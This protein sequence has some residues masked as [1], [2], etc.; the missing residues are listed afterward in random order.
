MAMPHGRKREERPPID[1]GGLERMALRYVER[2]ATSRGKL[3]RYLLRK[4]HERGWEGESEPPVT[5]IVDRMAALG[6]VD[7]AAF[8][9]ARATTLGRRGL[10]E[11]RIRA[12]LRAAGIADDDSAEAQTIARDQALAA[13]LRYA[14]RRRIGP[15]AVASPDRAGR[16]KALAAMLRAGHPLDLACR[17]AAA[18]PGEEIGPSDT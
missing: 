16:E 5:S 1:R 9:A 18:G 11:R 3:A 15:F 13:A 2:Y 14:Q 17:I 7:D 6:Y 8:A 10:G 4:L 12:D